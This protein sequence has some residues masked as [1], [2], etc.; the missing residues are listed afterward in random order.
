[1]LSAN[2]SPRD[3]NAAL[4]L[5][6]APRVFSRS[7]VDRAKRSSFVLGCLLSYGAL[8]VEAAHTFTNPGEQTLDRWMDRDAFVDGVDKSGWW[9]L[10]VPPD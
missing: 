7:Q 10:S 9:L 2:G 8:E 4:A 1:M 3:R 6:I 5:A